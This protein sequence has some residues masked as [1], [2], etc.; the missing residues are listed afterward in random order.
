MLELKQWFA[1]IKPEHFSFCISH[2][3]S[4]NARLTK[5]NS[6]YDNLYSD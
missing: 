3:S 5:E 1:I 2:F 6:A 4:G